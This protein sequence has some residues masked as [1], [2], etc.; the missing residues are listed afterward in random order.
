MALAVLGL[1]AISGGIVLERVF[2]T[3]AGFTLWWVAFSTVVI[4]NYMSRRPVRTR[5]G[6]VR[7]EDGAARYALPY[8]GLGVVIVISGIMLLAAWLIP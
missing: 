3:H 8:L 5:G 4:E 1:L 7:K 6:V 2:A